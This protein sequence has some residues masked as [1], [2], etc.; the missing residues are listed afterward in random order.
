MT[1]GPLGCRPSR[2]RGCRGRLVP[3]LGLSRLPKCQEVI[4]LALY[5]RGVP[6]PFAFWGIHDRRVDEVY[7]WFGCEAE[8]QRELRMMLGDATAGSGCME[9]VRLQLLDSVAWRN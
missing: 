4:R 5:A 1:L 7:L 2:S 6:S 9:V 3:K 8:A